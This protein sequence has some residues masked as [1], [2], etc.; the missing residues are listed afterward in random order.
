MDQLQKWAHPRPPL[1]L[2]QQ[3]QWQQTVSFAF[4][5]QED[6]DIQESEMNYAGGRD[7]TSRASQSWDK[8]VQIKQNPS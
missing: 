7:V 6:R 2:H 5:L 4:H 8:L 1:L 3:K